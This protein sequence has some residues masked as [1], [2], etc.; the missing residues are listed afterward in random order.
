M[1]EQERE[2]GIRVSW[3]VE[4][5][6]QDTRNRWAPLAYFVDQDDNTLALRYLVDQYF[7]IADVVAHTDL[8]D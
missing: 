2:L 3:G 7:R 1:A 8:D 4:A 5:E 6:V